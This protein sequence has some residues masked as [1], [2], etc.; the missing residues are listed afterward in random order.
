MAASRLLYT[1]VLHWVAQ[2]GNVDAVNS[3]IGAGADINEPN[4]DRWKPLHY[5]AHADKVSV[6]E[7]IISHGA[8]VDARNSKGQS[9]LG[10]QELSGAIRSKNCLSPMG[11]TVIER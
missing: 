11:Q 8:D 4:K 7:T 6:A 3:E 2:M 5:A 10:V 1:D 9:S